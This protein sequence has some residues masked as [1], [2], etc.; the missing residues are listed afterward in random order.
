[1]EDYFEGDE[2]LNE[3]TVRSR[4]TAGNNPFW[5]RWQSFRIIIKIEFGHAFYS[6]RSMDH[7]YDASVEMSV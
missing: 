2:E 6:Y 3:W 5:W 7:L 1:M 4:V